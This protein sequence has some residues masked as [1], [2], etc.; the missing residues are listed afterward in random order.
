MKTNLSTG[1]LTSPVWK[2]VAL[3]LALGGM[4]LVSIEFPA[5]VPE[6]TAP[7]VQPIQAVAVDQAVVEQQLQKRRDSIEAAR[8]EVL[9]QE[10]AK[11]R[12]AEQERQRQAR[13][14]AAAE[15]KRREK[16]EAE[17]R[18][19]ERKK[20]EQKRR[21]EAEKQRQR[22]EAERKKRE[23]E[24]QKKAAE[25]RERAEQER[26]MQEKMA[27]ERAAQAQRRQR[28]VLSEKDKYRALIYQAISSRLLMDDSMRGKSCRVNIKLATTGFVVQV[29]VLGGDPYVCR[30]TENAILKAGKLPMS[31]EPDVYQE[32]KDIN[33]TFKPDL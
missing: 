23:R 27:Q 7:D 28:Y 29:K 6:I 13:A 1:M 31:S 22:E 14:K 25:A 18:E 20:A 9:R 11:R 2:S 24:A 32:L 10:Q 8:Q 16:I 19:A 4:L 12:A 30:A 26:I 21:E 15:K 33:V 5:H 17:R 3:H